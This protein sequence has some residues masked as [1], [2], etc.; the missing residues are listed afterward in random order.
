[1]NAHRS[2]AL[3]PA[4]LLAALL[5]VTLLLQGCTTAPTAAGPASPTGGTVAE[6]PGRRVA[7]LTVERDWLL[8]FFRGTPVV[9]AQGSDGLLNVDVPREFCFDANRSTVKPALGAVLD[10]V[11]ES[12]RRTRA[13]LPVLAAPADANGSSTLA[14]QRANQMRSHLLGRGV[15]ASQIGTPTASSTAM[16][17]LRLDAAVQ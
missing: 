5:A 9:I 13:R 7:S 14:L 11:A 3:A 15:P 2:L 10:K 4:A 12:L 16:A 6:P 17:Q 1:M 8:S